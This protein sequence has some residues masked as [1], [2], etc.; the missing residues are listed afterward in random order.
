VPL[1]HGV[2]QEGAPATVSVLDRRGKRLGTVYLGHMPEPGQGTL[3][4]Q[5]NALLQDIFS[6]ADSPGLR[7]VSV[8]DAGSHPSDYSHRV[9]K[10]MP[11]PRRPWR[12][13]EWRR[14]IAYY[15][16]CQYMQRLADGI[17]GAGAESQRW[18]KRIRKQL[19]AKA[20]GVARVLQ[21]ASALRRGRGL[22]GQDPVFEQADAYLKTR[23]RW[24]RDQS[25]R[26]QHLPLGSGSTEAA[27]KLSSRS[28]AN[29]RGWRG[30]LL[31][32]TSSW[33]CG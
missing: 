10:K 19:K 7:L 26:R 17:F 8:T 24:M 32:D 29:A 15:Q 5:L 16:A 11:D 21:S 12:R 18:A 27:Y 22:S 20:A 28:G 4:T 33:T 31:A 30:R 6:Q 3:T 2:W 23:R 13:R 9:L 14:I 1:R 25:Y